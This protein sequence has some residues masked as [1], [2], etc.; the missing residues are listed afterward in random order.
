MSNQFEINRQKDKLLKKYQKELAYM[1][2]DK[3]FSLIL[4]SGIEHHIIKYS[5][6]AN[7]NNIEELLPN[8]KDYKIILVETKRNSGHWTAVIR[9][10]NVIEYFD[11]YGIRPDGEFRFISMIMQKLL[12]ESKHFL[13]KLLKDTK[14]K[15]E[16]NNIEF[17]Q[18]G[19]NVCTCGRWVSLFLKMSLMGYSLNAFQEFM[20]KNKHIYK[21]P[22]DI[23]AVDMTHSFTG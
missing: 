16:W 8:D 20:K 12:G 21:V 13:S 5:E 2:S 23:L 14:L 11:S 17:Q 18:D 19:S 4:G 7:Y 1:M 15:V 6:L 3:D 22:F 10:K 9:N